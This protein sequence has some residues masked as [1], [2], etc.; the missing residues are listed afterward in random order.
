MEHTMPEITLDVPVAIRL[1]EAND[2]ATL[3]EDATVRDRLVRVGIPVE[4]LAALPVEITALRTAQSVW[5]VTRDR[6]NPKLSM[7]TLSQ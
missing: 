4:K 1:Q 3:L 7:R 6:T 5:T 2:V